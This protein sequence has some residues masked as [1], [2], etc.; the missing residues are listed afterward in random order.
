MEGVFDTER[1]STGG[2]LVHLGCI[3]R[4]QVEHVRPVAATILLHSRHFLFALV[5]L[6]FTLEEAIS[7]HK[8]F[9]NLVEK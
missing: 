1:S 2:S 4:K 9:Y 8:M 6:T 3:K 5:A 7:N